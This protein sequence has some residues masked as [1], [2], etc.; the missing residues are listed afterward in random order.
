[1]RPLRLAMEAFGPYAQRQELDFSRFGDRGLFLIYGDTGAGKTMIF[2]AIAYALFGRA[3]GGRDVATL[4]SD[5][6]PADAPT[7]VTLDFEHAGRT[8][9]VTRAPQQMLERRRRTE[10]ASALV[11]RAAVA[12]LTSGEEVLASGT[13]AVDREVAGLLG[14]DYNQFRQ[15]TMIAQGAFRELLN[16]DPD[17]REGVLRKIF[18]TEELDR[19]ESELAAGARNSAEA[20][21][22]ARADFSSAVA[23]VDVQDDELGR[24]GRLKVL[25]QERPEL[26]AAACVEALGA[27]VEAER[28]DE[29]DVTA[30]MGEAKRETQAAHDREREAQEAVGAVRELRSARA[31][32]EAARQAESRSA[33]ALERAAA[34]H[35]G[36][37]RGLVA[38]EAELERALPRYDEL[39]RRRSAVDGARREADAASAREEGLRAHVGGLEER[40]K[41]AR[42]RIAA[43]EGA[44]AELARTTSELAASAQLG[45]RLDA[46]LADAAALAEAEAGLG[47][48]AARAEAAR[49]AEACATAE[50][51]A[52]FSSLVANDA[53]FVASQLREGEPCPVCGSTTHPAPARPAESAADAGALEA[54][55]AAQRAAREELEACQ[56]AYLSLRA[57]VRER[58]RALRA[59]ATRLLGAEVVAAAEA[60]GADGAAS[61][62]DGAQ[63]AAAEP[64]SAALAAEREE[65]AHRTRTLEV[66]KDDLADRLDRVRGYQESLRADEADL[67]EARS[68]LADAG[69]ASASAA[70]ERARA[71]AALDELAGSL[72]YPSREE[73]TGQLESVRKE[74]AAVEGALEAARDAH[75]AA[76]QDV[77]AAEVLL[78][79]R[80]KRL[81]ELGASEATVQERLSVL[82]E[83][84]IKAEAR[85]RHLERALRGAYARREKNEG[86]LAELSS[87]E[88]GLPEL[89]AR[90]RSAQLI[91]DVARGRGSGT[92]HISFERYVL[93][94]YFDQVIICA[95]RRLT[96]MSDGHF[97]LVRNTEGE[98][99]GKG[100]LSLDV[101]DYATGKRRPVSSLSGGETFEAS[102]S[103]ALGLSDYAQQQAGGMHL[104]T[105]FI[106]E[107]FGSL[108]PESLELVM[109]VLAEL[110]SGDCLVGI[111][112]HVEELEKRIDRRIEV[113]KTL[114]GSRAQ[115]VVE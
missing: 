97:E 78:D 64:L 55:R 45:G 30:A 14:L 31:R 48:A 57:G 73:A 105:V 8:Y 10:G 90:A 68:D 93:G 74:V 91:A 53:A 13:K 112:S 43:E 60:A 15:V 35:E 94:F 96:V 40:V 79:A 67:M 27:L 58:T 115:V 71:E 81:E 17:A 80:A 92:N 107:G 99:R 41:D 106:D 24:D 5:F 75:N 82:K 85:Q 102:L 54:S 111:I 12:T 1:M 88:R 76:E 83:A 16:A 59:A 66:R 52:A 46:A 100:G 56:N 114:E 22:R 32:L 62:A 49:E 25:V 109:Q 28:Q 110:A 19:L 61:A 26:D 95:N 7:S 50:A 3:S 39:E 77:A 86:L 38:R 87:L 108:D 84:A 101:I 65:V 69:A 72:E 70:G 23:R 34:E 6:S 103:L 36:R 51:D 21:A 2:D 4:R 98:S 20:L 11:S 63:A 42:A 89:E 33:E 29:L 18:G 9:S 104:D 47:P 113:S 37:H 44:E